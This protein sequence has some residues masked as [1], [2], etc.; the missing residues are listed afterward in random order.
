MDLS[1][2]IAS[3]RDLDPDDAS[4]EAYRDKVEGANTLSDRWFWLCCYLRWE[5]NRK[6][7]EEAERKL[8]GGSDVADVKGKD[9]LL[10]S[11]AEVA[12]EALAAVR[13]CELVEEMR[14]REHGNVYDRRFTNAQVRDEMIRRG[15]R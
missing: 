1:D 9:R 13:D 11:E 7:M 10:V 4:L 14:A 6:A 12:R 3:A 15:L 2:L 8:S 5:A